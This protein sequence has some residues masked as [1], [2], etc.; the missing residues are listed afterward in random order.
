MCQHAL[1]RMTDPGFGITKKSDVKLENWQ[2][3]LSYFKESRGIH[4]HF[5]QRSGKYLMVMS[6]DGKYF[7]GEDVHMYCAHHTCLTQNFTSN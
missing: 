3:N 4:T 5:W 6:E 1:S 7:L 2:I